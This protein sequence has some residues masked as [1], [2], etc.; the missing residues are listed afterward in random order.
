MLK[1]FKLRPRAGA[2]MKADPSEIRAHIGRLIHSFGPNPP[3]TLRDDMR[4]AEDL[5]LDSLD[6]EIL[7]NALE[8]E[9]EVA[10]GDPLRNSARTLGDVVAA[11]VPVRVPRLLA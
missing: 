10:I 2:R 3:L 5:G 6:V 8:D 1:S 4:L 11:I 9:F 7:F